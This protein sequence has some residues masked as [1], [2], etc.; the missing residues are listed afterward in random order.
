MRTWMNFGKLRLRRKHRAE[1]DATEIIIRKK[2]TFTYVTLN[3]V[4]FFEILPFKFSVIFRKCLE[5]RQVTGR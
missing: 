1:F 3:C 4:F 2:Y 5:S